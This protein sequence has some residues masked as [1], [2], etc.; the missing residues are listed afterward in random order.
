MLGFY[1]P[2]LP[3]ND[4]P[5]TSPPSPSEGESP[6]PEEKKNP[7]DE[8]SSEKPLTPLPRITPVSS[9]TTPPDRTGF[10][11]QHNRRNPDRQSVS[12]PTRSSRSRGRRRGKDRGGRS[13]S[14][15]WAGNRLVFGSFLL[16]VA[17]VFLFGLYLG[18]KNGRSYQLSHQIIQ[19]DAELPSSESRALL[20][21]AFG[22]L[23]AG[24]Y[25]QAM[26]D[27]RKVQEIQPAL[28]G[29]DFLIAE[30]A[31]RAGENDM[32]EDAA[33]Q[34]V[35]KNEAADQARVLLAVINM[36]KSKGK[37]Q[38]GSQLAD[39][40]AAAENEMR[41]FSATQP[42]DAKIY[43]LWGDLLRSEGA[44]RSAADILH[45][46]VLRAVSEASRE[47]L[48]AKEQLA[49]LQNDPAKTAPSL[50]ELT[51]M[52]GEQDLVA[53]L[54]SLQQHQSE[55]AAAFLEKARDLYSP[56]AFRELLRDGAFND[57]RNDPVMKPFF[58]TE[59]AS[60]PSH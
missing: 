34:A 43:T 5:L 21:H 56:Q 11:N 39:P 54:A 41:N 59:Y 50:S 25:R 23:D 2:C 52:T 44:Y 1:T 30:S 24:N 13:L 14:R 60:P 17:T 40:L 12:L 27:F 33:G 46:G 38:V 31:Y 58:K 51:S 9:E 22:S 28:S 32:A 53:A 47:V 55:M 8:S 4:H 19:R 45:Q 7:T 42:A 15:M 3:M 36:N 20:E 16:G 6:L 29:I 37:E 49:R 35:S 48:S 57:F 18:Q 26:S 10:Y